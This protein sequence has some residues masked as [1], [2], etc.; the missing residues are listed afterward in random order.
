LLPNRSLN[1]Y[2]AQPIS[3]VIRALAIGRGS[4]ELETA[5]LFGLINAAMADAGILCWQQKYKSYY[6]RPVTG[7]RSAGRPGWEPLGAPRSNEPGAPNF[8]PPFPAYPSGHATFG[9]A[10][11]H[12]ARLFYGV[13]AGNRN[14][15]TLFAGLTFVS[16][17]LDGKT[18]DF[19][20]LP[21]PLVPRQ[22]PGGLW[23]MI[24]ENGFSRVFLG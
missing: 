19:N 24:Q 2:P 12:M 10:A 7:L 18:I 11:L 23:Q 5:S 21:R 6:A 9:A 8:T 3:Q 22:F 13:P 16:D 4:S 15:D 1:V 14:N 17:E 20:G